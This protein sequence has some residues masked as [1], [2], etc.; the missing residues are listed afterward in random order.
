MNYNGK[1]CVSEGKRHVT[2]VIDSHT[3]SVVNL[4][5]HTVSG[6]LYFVIR[7]VF[8]VYLSFTEFHWGGG[9]CSQLI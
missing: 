3:T 4:S 7:Y 1:R 9:V 8:F 5:R 2:N 6:I